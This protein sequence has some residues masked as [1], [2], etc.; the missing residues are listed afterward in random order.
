MLLSQSDHF[1]ACGF[2]FSWTSRSIVIFENNIVYNEDFE[3]PR[4]SQWVVLIQQ[5]LSMPLLRRASKLLQVRLALLVWFK[6]Q[7]CLELHCSLVLE[8]IVL[9]L[10]VIFDLYAN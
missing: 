10:N 8:G 9:C 3:G 6:T 7:R 1:I 2:P 5:W 4:W